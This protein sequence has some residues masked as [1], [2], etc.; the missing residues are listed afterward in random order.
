MEYSILK[1]EYGDGLCFYTPQFRL[2]EG[3]WRDIVSSFMLFPSRFETREEA[4]EIINSC[5]RTKKVIETSRE[6]I[7]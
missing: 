3:E 1:Q 5:I 6:I 2:S 7:E 4:L